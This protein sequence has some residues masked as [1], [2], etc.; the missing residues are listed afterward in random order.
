MRR[1]FSFQ[2]LPDTASFDR[3]GGCS[4]IPDNPLHGTPADLLIGAETA[5]EV[6]R[7][8]FVAVS[9]LSD[10]YLDTA[11]LLKSFEGEL[12]NEQVTDQ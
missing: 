3:G 1:I 6:R 11:A 9:K 8:K 7:S 4:V 12:E 5:V 10:D 2:G